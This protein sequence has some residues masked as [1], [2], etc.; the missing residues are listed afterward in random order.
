MPAEPHGEALALVISQ[1]ERMEGIAKAKPVL[2][3]SWE[4]KADKPLMTC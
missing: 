3:F 2:E 4:R 1:R